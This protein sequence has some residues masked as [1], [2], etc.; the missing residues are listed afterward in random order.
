MV[1]LLEYRIDIAECERKT[2]VWRRLSLKC[3]LKV[4]STIRWNFAVPYK[5]WSC[6]ILTDKALPRVEQADRRKIYAIINSR[7]LP[8]TQMSRASLLNVPCFRQ[9]LRLG[10]RHSNFALGALW[11]C[12]QKQQQIRLLMKFVLTVAVAV[13]KLRHARSAVTLHIQIWKEEIQCSLKTSCT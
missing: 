8:V 3:S 7:G 6:I 1:Y 11:R 13:Q 4:L 9:G 10:F 2:D 5:P 12:H